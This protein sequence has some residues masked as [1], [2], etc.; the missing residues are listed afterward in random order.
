MLITHGIA[1]DSVIYVLAFDASRTLCLPGTVLS[2]FIF[3]IAIRLA[4]L[5]GRVSL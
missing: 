4:K 1:A 5:V 2:L 3:F